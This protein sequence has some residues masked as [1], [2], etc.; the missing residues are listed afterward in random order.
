MRFSRQAAIRSNLERRARVIDAARAFFTAAGF[1]EIE[2]PVRI[3]APAPE[4]HIDAQESGDWFLQPSPE[5]CMKRLLASG[6]E[7]IFQIC[8]CFRKGERGGRHVPEMTL[9]EWYAAGFDYLDLMKQCEELIGF[10]ADRIGI[11]RQLTYQGHAV[12]L[13]QPWDRLSVAGAFQRFGGMT[14][15]Q[16]LDRDCFDEIMGIE[17]ESKLGFDRP[18]FL[19]DYPAQCGALARLKPGDPSV[20]ER[21]ELYIAGMELCNAFTELTDPMEQRVRFETENRAREANGKTVYPI[22]KPFLQALETM[23]PAA[24]NALGLDRLVMLF[25][26]AASID[27]VVAFTPEEL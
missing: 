18:L 16:A 21:F 1:L 19:Y 20:A 5:L 23:P 12:D 8:R 9:L 17:I 7:K 27:E 11:G 26:D 14:A 6:Y 15:Q 13:T 25:A 22:A 10:V 24:G 4:A 3:P 2:T